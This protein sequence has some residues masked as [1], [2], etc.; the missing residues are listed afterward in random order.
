DGGRGPP[1]ARS[2]LRAQ[3]IGSA[4]PV[5]RALYAADTLLRSRAFGV[6]VLD[7]A[8]APRDPATWFRLARLAAGT[9]ALLLLLQPGPAAVGGSAAGLSLAVRLR[10]SPEP[11]WA[12]LRP[13]ALE[14]LVRRH[15]RAPA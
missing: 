8:P 6:V 3:G 9:R 14:V 11:P 4:S 13:P 2:R 7:L 12:E 10:P 1:H 15:R 5:G